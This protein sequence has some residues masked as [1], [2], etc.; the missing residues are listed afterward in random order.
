MNPQ[1]M[2]QQNSYIGAQQNNSP[3]GEPNANLP[4]KAP[5][6]SQNFS[7]QNSFGTSLPQTNAPPVSPLEHN[8]LHGPPPK[9]NNIVD[10][11]SNISLSGPQ[12]STV[13]CFKKIFY[14]KLPILYPY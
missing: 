3:F 4:P 1:F 5:L 13:S 7:A 10:Q 14:Y 2:Q 8:P 9:Q 12:K 11:M 6:D